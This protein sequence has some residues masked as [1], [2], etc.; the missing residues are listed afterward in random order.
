MFKLKILAAALA[1]VASTSG[2]AVVAYNEA[3]S[4]DLSGA[5]ASPTFVA[6]VSGS[7]QVLGT[8]GNPGT[9]TDRDYFTVTVPA[10][11][12]LSALTVLSGTAPLGLAFLG[13]QGGSQVTVS[14]TGGSPA[15]LLG[16]THYAAADVGVNVLPRVGT[17]A[18][19]TGFTGALPAGSYAFWIQD[20]NAGASTYNIDLTVTAVPEMATAASLL[21]G[22]GL[23]ALRRQRRP[24]H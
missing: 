14:P 12:L 6:L 11:S 5:G 4:G 20:F 10:G 3:V 13:V 22:L 23:L 15:G 16:W 2:H 1:V 24:A 7:N 18:G 9:G 21:L 17:G 19:A 8:T